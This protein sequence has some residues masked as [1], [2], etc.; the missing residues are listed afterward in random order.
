M[1]SITVWQGE[2]I[3]LTSNAPDETATDATLL[4]GLPSE[5]AIF[6]HAAPFTDGVAD[7]TV[8]DE[9]NTIPVGEYKY[10]IKVDYSDGA[11]KY[12]P[13]PD[14]CSSEDLPNFIVKARINS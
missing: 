6:E 13:S 7:L 5:T 2:T 3:S 11:T 12:F 9:D 4:I 10:M 8:T 14:S 1:K